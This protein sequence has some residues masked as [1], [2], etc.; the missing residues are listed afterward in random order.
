MYDQSR[1]FDIRQKRKF[2]FQKIRPSAGGISRT[3]DTKFSKFCPWNT[4]SS[5]PR[6]L[7]YL[8]VTAYFPFDNNR[9]LR[10]VFVK[11]MKRLS[12]KEGFSI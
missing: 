12:L 4:F 2:S 5:S 11:I 7:I 10:T 9:F 3:R 1:I 6:F 8:S